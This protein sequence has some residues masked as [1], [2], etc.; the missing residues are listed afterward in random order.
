MQNGKTL[1]IAHDDR[2]EASS[3]Q[4][5][6]G[7]SVNIVILPLRFQRKLIEIK[8]SRILNC[9]AYAELMNFLTNRKQLGST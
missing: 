7:R 9:D 2:E 6:R 5:L 4:Q 8:L 3:A 1:P